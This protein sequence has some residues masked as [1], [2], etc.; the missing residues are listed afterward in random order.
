M[1]KLINL[2]INNL[3]NNVPKE[4]IEQYK[5]NPQRVDIVFEGGLFNGSYETGFMYYL[6]KM[7][8]KNYIIVDKLSGCSIGSVQCLLYFMNL[9]D[10]EFLNR[11]LYHISYKQ[12]KKHN[13]INIFDELFKYIKHSLTDNILDKVNN[14]LYISY[15]NIKIGKQVVKSYYK[16][17]DDLFDTI[18]R[19]C[20][21]PI[22][23]DNNIF[24]KTK[25]MDGIYPYIFN[26][27]KNKRII[28]LNISN[29]SYFFG[30]FSIKN[31]HKTNIP[32]ILDGIYDSHLFFTTSYTTNMCSYVDDWGILLKIKRVLME[33]ITKNVV[34]IL[35][36]C[37]IL[38]NIIRKSEYNSVLVNLNN[39]HIIGLLKIVY[40]YFIKTWSI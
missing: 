13:N 5:N 38:Y 35:N 8:N 27:N 36:K 28:Y 4:Y 39:E 14:R 32:R 25:Y 29:L 30:I 10:Y 19:S 23:T 33:K 12:L 11:K 31:E 3:L 7:E 34:Y 37:L 21:V 15:F 26:K 40:T 2:Y 22:V 16:D 17:I 20:S 9:E 18:R 6:K 1:S 24:Y